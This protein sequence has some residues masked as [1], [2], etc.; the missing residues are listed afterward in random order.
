MQPCGWQH[1]MLHRRSP[2]RP[3][4][5]MTEPRHYATDALLRDG[6]SI[7]IRAIRPDDKQRL[8]DLFERLS[9]QSVYFSFFQTKQR[10]TDA[11]LRYFTELDFTRDA[12]LVATL[13][14]GQEAHIIGVGRYFRIQE[15]GQP[16]TRAEVA[17]TVADAHQGRGVGTL[18]LEHLAAWPGGRGSTPSR[19]MC[20]GRIIACWRSSR[21]AVSRC[22]ALSTPASSMS[23]S[24]RLTL[25]R[26]RLPVRSASASPRP[27][28]CGP[29]SIR[30][31]SPWWGYRGAAM[32]WVRHC[33]P[34]CNGRDLLV[35]CTPFIRMRPRSLA[36]RPFPASAP[37][38]RR[39]TLRSLLCQR[40]RWR[41]SWPIVPLPGSTVWWSFPRGLRKPPL[42]GGRQSSVCVPWCVPRGCAWSAPTVWAS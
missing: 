26:C 36:C 29:F 17:F 34:I 40:Q 20:W 2:R 16:T 3:M 12:A 39:W 21:R 32:A 9:S 19:P 1:V 14:V 31:R 38:G 8:L 33:S 6:G 18:L 5:P 7:H 27:R 42:S 28:A 41:R 23:P 15:H 13:R 4:M 30:V 22:S 11:E 10:L 24:R 25:L 37:W 35:D